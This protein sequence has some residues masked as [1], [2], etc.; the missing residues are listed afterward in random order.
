MTSFKQIALMLGLLDRSFAVS[1]SG[2]KNYGKRLESA[3]KPPRSM[4][5]SEK[6]YYA[7]HKNLIGHSGS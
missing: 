1:A 7:K 5:E 4:T 3:N 2:K 6:A